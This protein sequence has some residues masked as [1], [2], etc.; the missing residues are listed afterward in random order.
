MCTFFTL[1]KHVHSGKLTINYKCVQFIQLTKMYNLYNWQK[2]TIYTIDKYVQFIQLIKC[3]LCQNLQIYVHFVVYN[4]CKMFSPAKCNNMRTL[5]WFFLPSHCR[6]QSK[7]EIVLYTLF[8]QSRP[9]KFTRLYRTVST[10]VSCSSEFTRLYWT[11]M[12]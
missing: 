11:K 3:T 12:T 5:L 2:C 6:L 4:E 9:T 8:G 1:K 7:L 10:F